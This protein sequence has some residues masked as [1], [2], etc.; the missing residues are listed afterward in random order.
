[1]NKTIYLKGKANYMRPFHRDMGESATPDHQEKILRTDGEYNMT[2][3]LVNPETNEVFTSRDDA[4]DYLESKGVP[5]ENMF[6]NY[7]KRN[8]ETKE[9]LYKVKRPHMEPNM[10]VE[11][12]SDELGFVFGH[13]KV[14]NAEKEPWD[15]ETLIGND[16]DLTVKINVWRGEKVTKIRWDGV[17]IDEL[18]P[19]EMPE[20]EEAF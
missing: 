10:P 19:Y 12:D 8:P 3:K 9:V 14:V 4:V 7:V 15:E 13:P 17:R 20:D 18:V 16:S 2:F 11:K 1:M 5:T 6:G